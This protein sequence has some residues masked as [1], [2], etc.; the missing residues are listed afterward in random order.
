MAL[1]LEFRYH[2]DDPWLV[3]EQAFDII[4]DYVET[5]SRL[6]AVQAAQRLD[7]LESSKRPLNEGEHAEGSDGFLLEFWEVFVATIKQ[8]PHDRDA[9]DRI[10]D[11]LVELEK[12]PTISTE[13]RHDIKTDS[14]R[15]TAAACGHDCRT[16]RK[17]LM[18]KWKVRI[19]YNSLRCKASKANDP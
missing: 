17:R 15:G 7:N 19:E 10:V 6:S 9:Q 3:V 14:P 13:V 11:L 8:I 12:L 18:S 16:Y 2:D 4:K 5:S 1:R